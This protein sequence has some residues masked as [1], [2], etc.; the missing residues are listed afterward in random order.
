M[1]EKCCGGIWDGV[2]SCSYPCGNKGK[3]QRDG[4]WY[5]GTHDPQKVVA[6]RLKNEAKW[7][8]ETQVVR[9][10]YE[11]A[12]IRGKQAEAFPVL[13]K[14]LETV[15][16]NYKDHDLE[17]EFGE[18]GAVILRKAFAQADAIEKEATD[19]G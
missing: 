19:V 4:K 2:S 14:A 11:A 5:C 9:D 6:R 1:A 18:Q 3:V 15:R 16:D 10:A 12:R 7:Q 17:A 8:T 13:V